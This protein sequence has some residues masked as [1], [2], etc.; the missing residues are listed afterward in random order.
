MCKG[1]R[2][3]PHLTE[4]VAAGPAFHQG[5]V[6]SCFES[7]ATQL[8]WVVLCGTNR[9]NKNTKHNNQILDFSVRMACIYTFIQAKAQ[10]N[11]LFA[12]FCPCSVMVA[13]LNAP[14]ADQSHHHLYLYVHFSTHKPLVKNSTMAF[15]KW[16]FKKLCI[17]PAGGNLSTAMKPSQH[18][19]LRV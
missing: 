9:L 15:L 10:R 1:G 5:L 11:S 19:L 14:L 2:V 8:A 4:D 17:L 6:T 16:Y 18:G 7:P 3:L 12:L 13:A